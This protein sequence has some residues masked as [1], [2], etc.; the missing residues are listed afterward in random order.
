MDD[1]KREHM[2][3]IGRQGGLTHKEKGPDYFRE[4]GRRGG[5]KTRE[6]MQDEDFRNDHIR[7]SRLGKEFGVRSS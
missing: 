7:R 6:L 4:L 2:A 1:D 5:A 3:K